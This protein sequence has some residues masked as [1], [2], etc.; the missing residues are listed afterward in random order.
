MDRTQLFQKLSQLCFNNHGFT[1]SNA[2]N[3]LMT[4]SGCNFFDRDPSQL[5]C[6][7]SS[8]SVSFDTENSAQLRSTVLELAVTFV[9]ILILFIIS[10]SVGYKIRVSPRASTTSQEATDLRQS[11]LN[12][13]T[14]PI[15]LSFIIFYIHI[16]FSLASRR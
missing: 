12:W 11:L 8:T 1:D 7:Y 2:C 9:S 5:K 15:W 3:Q 10:F 4:Q 14:F 6:G 16:K 13:A